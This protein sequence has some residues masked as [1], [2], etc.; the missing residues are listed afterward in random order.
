MR[1]A[2]DVEPWW[3]PHAIPLFQTNQTP[4]SMAHVLR[5]FA[6]VALNSP[7]PGTVYGSAVVGA[8]IFLVALTLCRWRSDAFVAEAHLTLSKQNLD[9]DWPSDQSW[10]QILSET[11][12]VE[13][14]AEKTLRRSDVP[15]HPIFSQKPTA[16]QIETDST[17]LFLNLSLRC[18]ETRPEL[19]IQRTNQLGNRLMQSAFV[20]KA[21]GIA[22]TDA[23][24]HMS[25]AKKADRQTAPLSMQSLS[26]CLLL[27]VLLTIAALVLYFRTALIPNKKVLE[28]ILQTRVVA[29]VPSPGY[30]SPAKVKNFFHR[31]CAMGEWALVAMLLAA[32]AVAITDK[33]FARQ[34]FGQPVTALADG[35]RQLTE[36]TRS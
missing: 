4:R 34:L 16:L 20:L 31:L 30:T 24:W 3:V 9:I 33:H 13:T 11:L 25:P 2:V 8:A 21:A 23:T 5:K 1:S 36:I 17:P 19:A 10:E 12:A 32:I 7:R 14:T 29:H 26:L 22:P 28:K 6:S 27:S 15:A 35:F 18:V